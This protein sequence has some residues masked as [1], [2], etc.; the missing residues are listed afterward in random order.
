M[1]SEQAVKELLLTAM[2][3][4]RRVAAED[5]AALGRPLT[6]GE[7]A[8]IADMVETQLRVAIAAAR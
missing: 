5:E 2:E 1:T 3:E 4:A 8:R 7:V 6:D